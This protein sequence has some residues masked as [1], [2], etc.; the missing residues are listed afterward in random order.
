MFYI[1]SFSLPICLFVY[2]QLF[3]AH[4]YMICETEARE[5][6]KSTFEV[7]FFKVSYCGTS[8]FII[9]LLQIFLGIA[10]HLW[11]IYFNRKRYK[12]FPDIREDKTMWG[13]RLHWRL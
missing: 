2:A 7:I 5:V 3:I 12:Y 10:P 9:L 8:I 6:V 4:E 13:K 11:G 1:L